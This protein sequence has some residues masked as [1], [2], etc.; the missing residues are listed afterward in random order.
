TVEGQGLAQRRWEPF[1]TERVR[2]V[3]QPIAVVV[4]ATRRAAED[5]AELAVPD[6]EP[7][8]AVTSIDKALAPDAPRLYADIHDNV[9]F[10]MSNEVGSPDAAFEKADVVLERR[11]SYGRQTPFPLEG[12]GAI[13]EVVDG[14]LQ[15]TT[16]TQIPHIVRQVVAGCLGRRQ[17]SVRVITPDVGGGFGL[18]LQVF[19]EEVIVAA[20][21]EALR[22]PIKWIE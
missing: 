4:A 11:F 6:I 20:L 8:E 13:A 22:R 17:D 10:A 12:R 5:A 18:K 1:A 14:R 16:S 9:L 21:A 3:G 2:Y 19:G 7:I 15:L